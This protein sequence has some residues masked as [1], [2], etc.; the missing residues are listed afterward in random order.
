MFRG[1]FT[2]S[3]VRKLRHRKYDP[4]LGWGYMNPHADVTRLGFKRNKVC[5]ISCSTDIKDP[6][7][8]CDCDRQQSDMVVGIRG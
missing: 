8:G 7:L 1:N 5:A 2:H 6:V 3:F 4:C